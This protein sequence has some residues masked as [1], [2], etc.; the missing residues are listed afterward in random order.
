MKKLTLKEA[1]IAVKKDTKEMLIKGRDYFK[2]EF[3]EEVIE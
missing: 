1:L 2:K 3:E